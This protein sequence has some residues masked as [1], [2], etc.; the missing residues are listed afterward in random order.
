MSS[1]TRTLLGCAS[2]S[3]RILLIARVSGNGN[4]VADSLDSVSGVG[5]EFTGSRFDASEC[6]SDEP[7][8]SDETS[9]NAGSGFG[10]RGTCFLT[11]DGRGRI[12]FYTILYAR[13]TRKFR[14]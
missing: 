11:G 10:T 8:F 6:V 7:E 1:K 9:R 2:Y 12:T 3:L 14:P 4:E 13:A 5:A